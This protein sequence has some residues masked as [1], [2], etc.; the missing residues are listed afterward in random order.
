MKCI[1]KKRWLAYFKGE[2]REDEKRGFDLHLEQCESC[3]RK[4]REYSSSFKA[5]GALESLEPDAGFTARTLESIRGHRQ[6]KLWPRLVVPAV[7]TA[8]AVLSVALGIFLGYELYS[9]MLNGQSDQQTHLTST[10]PVEA[11]YGVPPGEIFNQGDL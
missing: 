1:D 6:I 4:S 8:A 10:Y 11:Q 7:A 2:F 3:R 9:A 5:L